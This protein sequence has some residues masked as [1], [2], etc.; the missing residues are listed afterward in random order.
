MACFLSCLLPC[1]PPAILSLP[2][3]LFFTVSFYYFLQF[4]IY[5]LHSFIL[6]P[7]FIC[8]HISL[9]SPLLLSF[10]LL[11]RLFHPFFLSRVFRFL[12]VTLKDRISTPFFNYL[13][14]FTPLPNVLIF[15]LSVFGWFNFHL[16]TFPS[17]GNTRTFYL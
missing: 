12:Y 5:H 14:Q 2:L 6:S 11:C 16:F 7:L 13:Y 8:F 9:L 10:F 3:L 4:L 15:D 1:P 17:Y